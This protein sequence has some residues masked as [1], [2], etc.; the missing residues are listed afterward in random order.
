[1]EIIID[2]L[3]ILIV[4]LS[5]W[6]G[7]KKGLTENLLKIFNFFIALIISIIL[8]NPISNLVINNTQIDDFLQDS[9]TAKFDASEKIEES[10]KQNNM[11]V[12]FNNYIINQI[13]ESTNDAKEVII[14]ESAKQISKTIIN[15]GIVILI[16]LVTRIILIFIKGIANI[17]TKLPVIKQ[18]DKLGRISIWI[19]ESYYNTN[20]YIYYNKSDSS[21]N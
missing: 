20:Y 18:C 11:P 21:N 16:F 7:Y 15:I 6:F 1:M 5:I 4:G 14:K 13:E 17:I 9:I 3:I 19:I 12:I 8:F 10:E 2:L